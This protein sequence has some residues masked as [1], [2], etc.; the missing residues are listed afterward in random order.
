VGLDG[1]AALARALRSSAGRPWILA[2]AIKSRAYPGFVIWAAFFSG[3]VASL[4]HLPLQ[5]LIPM[6]TSDGDSTVSYASISG[7]YAMLISCLLVFL[8]ILPLLRARDASV[9]LSAAASSAIPPPPPG[10]S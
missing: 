10:P 5:G 8:L 4:L 3:L 7:W 9:Q 2:D 1:F 6:F